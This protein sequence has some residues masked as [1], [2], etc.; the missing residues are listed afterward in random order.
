MYDLEKVKNII[1]ENIKDWLFEGNKIFDC[2]YCKWGD[3]HYFDIWYDDNYY[4]PEEGVGYMLFIS[5]YTHDIEDDDQYVGTAVCFYDD[6]TILLRQ[7]EEGKGSME[8]KLSRK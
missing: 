7:Y 8:Y 5:R 2:N 3:Y 4:P 1:S 6:N